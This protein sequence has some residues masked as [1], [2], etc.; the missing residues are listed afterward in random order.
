MSPDDMFHVF[1]ASDPA[2]YADEVETRWGG[3]LVDE[4]RRRTSTY[5]RQDWESIQEESD[6][7]LSDFAAAKRSGAPADSEVAR[8]VVERHRLHIDRWFYPC[9][10]AMHSDLGAMYV[11]DARFTAYWDQAE[12][13][14]ARYVKAAVDANAAR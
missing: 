8:S 9:S 1:G 12:S 4:S 5:R 2:D 11:A 14:L 6:Q 3:P 7:I 13:G 10:A